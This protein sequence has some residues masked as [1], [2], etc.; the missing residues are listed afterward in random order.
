MSTALHSESVRSEPSAGP[1]K[2]PLTS[3]SFFQPA[4][5]VSQ[6]RLP[7]TPT[8]AALLGQTGLGV[9][10][11][12]L[13][14]REFSE[15]QALVP[16]PPSREGAGA[17][18]GPWRWW[19]PLQRSPLCHTGASLGA[20]L[21]GGAHEALLLAQS[22]PALSRTGGLHAES[23]A[24]QH[25]WILCEMGAPGQTLGWAAQAPSG[26]LEALQSGGGSHLPTPAL[27]T[28]RPTAAAHQ[29]RARALHGCGRVPL[30]GLSHA[31]GQTE[32]PSCQVVK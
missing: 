8:C 2:S 1:L 6:S 15:G 17:G 14:Q 5:S 28:E 11:N 16:S 19:E 3:G 21:E 27:P 22:H 18:T 10:R 20:G 25:A 9:S 30:G 13:G 29:A 23:L 24:H 4:I 12:T 26:V 31:D 32:A 7:R